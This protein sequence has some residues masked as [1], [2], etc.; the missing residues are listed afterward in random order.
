[1]N[2]DDRH[3]TTGHGLYTPRSPETAES[4]GPARRAFMPVGVPSEAAAGQ[5]ASASAAPAAPTPAGPSAPAAQAPTS[6]GSIP[7]R[8]TMRPTTAS[9]GIPTTRAAAPTSPVSQPTP[10]AQ[11]ASAAQPRTSPTFAAASAPASSAPAAPTTQ[12]AP[13]FAPSHAPARPAGQPGPQFGTTGARATGA[14]QASPEQPSMLGTGKAKLKG[15]AVRAAESFKEGDDLST[16][17]SKGGP[18]RARVLVS[19]IDPWSALK[20]GFLMSIA[21]G[22]MFVV[23]VFVLWNV[24]NEMGTFALINQWVVDLFTPSSEIDIMQFFDQNKIM[25]A[26]ILLSVVNVVLLTALSTIAAFLYN[27]ISSVVGGFY[28][29]LTDD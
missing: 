17:A 12:A 22:I 7:Q 1:M 28:V 27:V 4:T 18:R 25:S 9:G 6:T 16:P 21:I 24:L 2:A 19:R 26:A 15:F 14:P 13:T 29:T 10:T 23:A 20:L 11:P 5:S 8:T 3:A